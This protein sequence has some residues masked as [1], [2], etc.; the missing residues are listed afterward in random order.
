MKNHSARKI[1]YYINKLLE[2]PKDKRTKTEKE[3]LEYLQSQLQ[4][5]GVK[6]Q[7]NQK[8]R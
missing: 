2:I 4:L 6:K 3:E 7:I 8:R 5:F 1:Q